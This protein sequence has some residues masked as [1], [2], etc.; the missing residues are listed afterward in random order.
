MIDSPFPHF[1]IL[2]Y[3]FPF[4]ISTHYAASQSSYVVV[5][6]ENVQN[7]LLEAR[8]TNGSKLSQTIGEITVFSCHAKKAIVTDFR[9]ADY[10]NLIATFVDHDNVMRAEI[11]NSCSRNPT[12]R[13]RT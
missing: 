4:P 3:H 1:L 6:V 12:L 7:P 13:V 9:D 2:I 8:K 11:A 10:M 5:Q